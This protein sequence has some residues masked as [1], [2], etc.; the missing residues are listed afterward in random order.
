MPLGAWA[1]VSSA[2]RQQDGKWQSAAGRETEPSTSTILGQ[3]LS[4]SYLLSIYPAHLWLVLGLSVLAVREPAA[5]NVLILGCR[6]R[7]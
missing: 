4:S 5:Q 7:P 6:G 3:V 2:Y 1:P